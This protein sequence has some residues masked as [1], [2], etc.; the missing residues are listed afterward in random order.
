MCAARS[1]ALFR[2]WI[3]SAREGAKTRA[4]HVC[5][6]GVTTAALARCCA[7]RRCGIVATVALDDPA[8]RSTGPGVARG[9]GAEPPRTRARRARDV[10]DHRARLRGVR[11]G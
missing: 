9:R 8:R 3:A 11:M 1:V 2:E 10:R 4:M 7:L 5:S 6:E